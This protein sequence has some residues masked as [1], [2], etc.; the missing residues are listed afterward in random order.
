MP[1]YDSDVVYNNYQQDSQKFNMDSWSES[2][3]SEE[4]YGQSVPSPMGTKGVRVRD[5]SSPY[6]L[7]RPESVGL[8]PRGRP[9]KCTSNTK[10][11]AYARNYREVKKFQMTQ[12]MQQNDDLKKENMRLRMDNHELQTSMKSLEQEIQLMRKTFNQTSSLV[13]VLATNLKAPG[14]S[15]IPNEQLNGLCLHLA[16]GKFT[17]EVCRQCSQSSRCKTDPSN[18][19][20]LAVDSG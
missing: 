11:A 17:I 2:C 6:P 1:W 5:V 12:C 13:S 19:S 14:S 8:A 7:S 9:P 20:S 15:A 4:P 18:P 10:M 16:D 3:L